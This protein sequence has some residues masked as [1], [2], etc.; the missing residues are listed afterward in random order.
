MRL[1]NWGT[2]PKKGMPANFL[3]SH[4]F[5]WSSCLIPMPMQPSIQRTKWASHWLNAKPNMEFQWKIMVSSRIVQHHAQP[6]LLWPCVPKWI[7]DGCH[8]LICLNPWGSIG[9]WTIGSCGHMGHPKCLIPY[10]WQHYCCPTCMAPLHCKLY[11]QFAILWWMPLDSKYN[12]THT[13]LPT[14]YNNTLTYN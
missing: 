13:I 7:N 5:H 2:Q 6:T 1:K 12:H 8:C 11:D 4:G 10:M 3:S 14:L 9:A